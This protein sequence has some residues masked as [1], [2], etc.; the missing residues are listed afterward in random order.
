MI[1]RKIRDK[2]TLQIYTSNSIYGG[3]RV[4]GSRRPHPITLTVSCPMGSRQ[5][6]F[7]NPFTHPSL[8][9]G[10]SLRPG[11]FFS[12]TAKP[13]LLE[14]NNINKKKKR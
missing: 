6:I 8:V 12:F 9:D 3:V 4:I 1:D 5:N 14:R 2:L 11:E 13:L 10:K 7:A